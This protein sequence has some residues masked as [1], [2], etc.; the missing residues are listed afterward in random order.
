MF[1]R[2][3]PR[4]YPIAPI[5]I[6]RQSTEEFYIKGIGMI[7]AGTRIAVNM[8]RLHYDPD[9]WG[10]VDPHQFYPERF[11]SKRH[12]MAWIP[13]GVGPRN[14]VG[15]RFALIE[16]KMTLVCLVKS[17]SVTIHKQR[18]G[19]KNEQK[20]VVIARLERRHDQY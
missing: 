20:N 4:L 17:S 10:P 1:I 15:M 6:N 18:N 5:V 8:Y 7:P 3:T 13:F 12:P 9:L 16:L 19:S 11:A 2:E 14:C